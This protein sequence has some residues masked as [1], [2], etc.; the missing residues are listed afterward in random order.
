LT[1]FWLY[2]MNDEEVAMTAPPFRSFRVETGG[3]HYGH[4]VVIVS[5]SHWRHGEEGVIEAQ[6]TFIRDA[7][8]EKIQREFAEEVEQ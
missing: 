4:F 7:I 8:M 6:R 2:D 1:V 5:P 3:E